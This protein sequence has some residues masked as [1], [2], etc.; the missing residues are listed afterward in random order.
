MRR[1]LRGENEGDRV[2]RE[3]ITTTAEF[4]Q[5]EELVVNRLETLTQEERREF[6]ASVGREFCIHCGSQYTD[7]DPM[8][9]CRRD[10]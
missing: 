1:P 2:K 5:F 9:F 7:E 6:F 10:D 8:C 3:F 4:D